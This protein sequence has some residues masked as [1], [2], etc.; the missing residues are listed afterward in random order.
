MRSANVR[1]RSNDGIR[2][3]ALNG[4]RKALLEEKETLGLSMRI[5]DRMGGKE[6][7]AVVLTRRTGD[8]DD[9]NSYI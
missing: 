3:A 8:R 2:N 7:L 4:K 5:A 9:V 1:S 6:R